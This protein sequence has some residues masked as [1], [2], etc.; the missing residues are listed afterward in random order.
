MPSVSQIGVPN[1]LETARQLGKQGVTVVI[2]SRDAAKGNAV[3]EKLRGEG[4]DVQAIR[5]DIT[6]SADYQEAYK[7]FDK[8]FGKLDA[9]Q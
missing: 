5:F 7:F 1:F 3:A 2:G 4:A 8:K 6:K 9:F